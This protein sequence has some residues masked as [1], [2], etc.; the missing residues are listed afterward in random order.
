MYALK[1]RGEQESTP[2]V[3]TGMLQ[4]LSINVY[5]LQDSG[6]TLYF[7]NPLVAMK[8]KVLP[9]V[10]IEP[11]SITTAVGDSVV[12]RRVFRCFPISLPNRVTLVYCI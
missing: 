4:V 8:F 1:A 5:G 6:A 10:L 11:F 9:D 7:L 3:V 2:D 12:P